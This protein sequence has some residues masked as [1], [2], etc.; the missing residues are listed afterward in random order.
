MYTLG[1][2]KPTTPAVLSSL[3]PA[4][5]GIREAKVQRLGCAGAG[6]EQSPP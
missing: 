1:K 2:V 4:W 5:G 3:T 6:K